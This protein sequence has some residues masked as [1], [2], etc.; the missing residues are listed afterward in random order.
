MLNGQERGERRLLCEAEGGRG[1][2]IK[3]FCTGI[4]HFSKEW[5]V[6]GPDDGDV[7][8]VDIKT[9]SSELSRSIK[10]ASARPRQSRKIE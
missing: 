9:R 10:Q 3:Q 4:R 8:G 2:M 1:R 7:T 5:R 6:T